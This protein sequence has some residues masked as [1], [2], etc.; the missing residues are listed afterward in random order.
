MYPKCYALS[1]YKGGIYISVDG[2]LKLLN[3]CNVVAAP[4]T[5]EAVF[6]VFLLTFLCNRWMY[7]NIL[8][9]KIINLKCECVLF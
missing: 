1:P 2:V 9:N 3:Y 8:K 4:V 5:I 7:L 6:T